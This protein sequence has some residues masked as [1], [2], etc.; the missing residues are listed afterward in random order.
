[1]RQ[2]GRWSASIIICVHL[3]C[4]VYYD[5]PGTLYWWCCVTHTHTPTSNVR[6]RPGAGWLAGF[7]TYT[8][9]LSVSK[10]LNSLRLSGTGTH[11]PICKLALEETLNMLIRCPL[12]CKTLEIN[13][14]TNRQN[15]FFCQFEGCK[16]I[17]GVIVRECREKV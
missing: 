11:L 1:M 10:P 14:P 12:P 17:C 2:P 16:R 13:P 7:I 8:V 4:I 5:T 3:S 6:S 15:W 9:Y